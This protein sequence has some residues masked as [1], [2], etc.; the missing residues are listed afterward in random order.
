M[1]DEPASACSPDSCSSAWAISSTG[2]PCSWASQS[3][4]ARVDRARAGG[5][6]EPLQ[7]SEAHRRVD[8]PALD[9]GGQRGPRA[10]VAGDQADTR[11]GVSHELDRAPPRVAVAQT[12]E[13]E[14]THTQPGPPFEWHGVGGRRLGQSRVKGGVEAAHRRHVAQ[15]LADEIDGSEAGRLVEGRQGTSPRRAS[16]VAASSRAGPTKWD[17]PWTI[18]WPTAPIGS[19][20]SARNRTS[21]SDRRLPGRPAG[22]R[23]AAGRRSR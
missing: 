13:A 15:D 16:V 19:A 21:A 4:Q 10:E 3:D 9:D 14:A 17:P 1:S 11:A 8:R 5:H 2:I 12:V 18:R 23:H 20:H 7:G 6:H 22:P